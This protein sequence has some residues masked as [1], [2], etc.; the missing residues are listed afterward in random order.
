MYVNWILKKAFRFIGNFYWKI[1][2]GILLWVVWF[3]LAIAFAVTIIGFPFSIQLFRISWLVFHPFGKQVVVVPDHLV[4][5]VIWLCSFGLILGMFCVF[6]WV[7][8]S[9]I[10]VG[11]PLFKQ[12]Y[13]VTKLAFFPFCVKFA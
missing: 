13:N 12:W 4:W 8:T 11:L 5:S 9:L 7:A 1:F 3:L 2:G 10:F 6:T